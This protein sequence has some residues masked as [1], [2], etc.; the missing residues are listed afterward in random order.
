MASECILP[1]FFDDKALAL[2]EHDVERRDRCLPFDRRRGRRKACFAVRFDRNE[3]RPSDRGHCHEAEYCSRDGGSARSCMGPKG[4]L[5]FII[6]SKS[7]A[8]EMPRGTGDRQVRHCGGILNGH[9]RR[10]VEASGTDLKRSENDRK[11]KTRL[12]QRR[13]SVR[14]KTKSFDMML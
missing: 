4:C 10:L 8:S 6:A 13:T 12:G 14:P 7:R 5:D 2:F 9:R 3:F 11:A 1:P